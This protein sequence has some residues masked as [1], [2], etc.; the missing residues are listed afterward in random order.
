[1]TWRGVLRGGGELG[2]GEAERSLEN[3]PRTEASQHHTKQLSV[4]TY[5]L[6]CLL[7]CSK[8]AAT[9]VE[10]RFSRLVVH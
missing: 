9:L 6:F 7:P 4:V 5:D 2:G 8:E 1:M 3:L 10:D